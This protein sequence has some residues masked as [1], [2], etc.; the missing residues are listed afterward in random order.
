[1]GTNHEY[2]GGMISAAGLKKDA[3]VKTTRCRWAMNVDRLRFPSIALASRIH[4][5]SLGAVG[6]A[7]PESKAYCRLLYRGRTRR[8][9]DSAPLQNFRFAARG[10]HTLRCSCSEEGALAMCDDR[11]TAEVFC[12]A[13]IFALRWRNIRP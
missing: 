13:R 11:S 7:F 8:A 12:R 9:H 6:S 3:P 2:G 1:M 5:S 10:G 4:G